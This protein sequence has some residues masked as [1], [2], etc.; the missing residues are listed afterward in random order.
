ML[1]IFV[2]KHSINLAKAIRF[3]CF[4]FLNVFFRLITFAVDRVNRPVHKIIDHT[5]WR[6]YIRWYVSVTLYQVHAPEFV[7]CET[8]EYWQLFSSQRIDRQAICKEEKN[9]YDRDYMSQIFLAILCNFA[10]FI[11]KPVILTEN[12]I[13]KSELYTHFTSLHIIFWHTD[14]KEV[15]SSNYMELA[16]TESQNSNHHW[17]VFLCSK[18]SFVHSELIMWL[19]PAPLTRHFHWWITALF[20]D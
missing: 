18:D 14:P 20:T 7:F 8:T 3:L 19:T 2:L 10:A 12:M 16:F 17:T 5:Q 11:T 9:W 13:I 4:K 1:I 6:S 15:S